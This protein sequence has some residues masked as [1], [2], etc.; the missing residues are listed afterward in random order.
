MCT[1]A[2]AAQPIRNARTLCVAEREDIVMLDVVVGH[3]SA[4]IFQQ[5]AGERQAQLVGRNTPN[6]SCG[7]TRL[8]VVDG[9][10]SPNLQRGRPPVRGRHEDVEPHRQLDQ[11]DDGALLDVVVGQSPAIRELPV[12]E[13]Q[14]QPRD[15]LV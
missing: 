11:S 10:R 2:C 3:G 9:V 13:E 12:A 1:P 14:A 8:D 7:H 5:I 6:K 15:A 4:A